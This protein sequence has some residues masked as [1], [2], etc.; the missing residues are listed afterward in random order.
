MLNVRTQEGEGE[1]GEGEGLDETG[2][3][4]KGAKRRT[5]YCITCR[6]ELP[7]HE[8]EEHISGLACR[9]VD[10]R[11]EDEGFDEGEADAEEEDEEEEDD[12]EVDAGEASDAGAEEGGEL[13]DEKQGQE[14]DV[15]APPPPPPSPAP[16]PATSGAT[17]T[18]PTCSY[19]SFPL[20]EQ[21]THGRH[22]WKCQ[23]CNLTMHRS[24][25]AEHKKLPDHTWHCDLCNK[26]VTRGGRG[27]HE[28]SETHQAR[29]GTKVP[30]VSTAVA[31]ATAKEM[32]GRPLEPQQPLGAL[33]CY[34]CNNYIPPTERLQHG[35][36]MW[37][38]EICRTLTHLDW[39]DAHM[40]Q[41]HGVQRPS[42]AQAPSGTYPSVAAPDA[43]AST[44]TKFHC[45]PCRRT[46][47]LVDKPTH[48]ASAV[49]WSNLTSTSIPASKPPVLTRPT[50]LNAPT[51]PLVPTATTGSESHWK[52][53]E[54]RI[55]MS[56]N[57]MTS[58]IGGK[59]HQEAV[60]LAQQK[61]TR[62]YCGFCKAPV[63]G[64]MEVHLASEM[65]KTAMR[66]AIPG[67]TAPNSKPAAT[68]RHPLPPPPPNATY[69]CDICGRN[70]FVAQR[71]KH[72]S[73]I[74]HTQALRI[75]RIAAERE[76]ERL[77]KKREEVSIPVPVVVNPP[78]APGSNK[79][80]CEA[81]GVFKAIV[82]RE[83][84]MKSKNHRK[85]VVEW[86]QQ[87]AVKTAKARVGVEGGGKAGGAGVKEMAHK[88]RGY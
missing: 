40:L 37:C 38:C 62:R 24:Q 87:Q 69:Y 57:N 77:V 78:P 81:C 84:H 73:G 66:S 67:F 28:N 29:M 4:G 36:P 32:T 76:A 27:A 15:G 44:S 6:S 48:L 70:V 61:D 75:A 18:C 51:P 68:G 46:M 30:E 34:A 83:G 49:H 53:A 63:V 80:Y 45:L 64:G 5:F 47:P 50:T 60:R 82:G 11:M 72:L 10:E 86:E 39:K 35:S 21:S 7:L 2:Y 65:H 26:T 55:T 56:V 43:S 31:G 88:V 79:F 85:K 71:D 25:K 52:C 59:K 33:F 23:T 16:H 8:Q 22:I 20:S 3:V 14:K 1:E 19:R 13:V 58:H 9:T 42:S 54:C 41:R 17:F 74:I 12:S